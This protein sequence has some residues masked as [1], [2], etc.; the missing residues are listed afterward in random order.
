MT[1]VVGGYDVNEAFLEASVPLVELIASL[2]IALLIYVGTGQLGGVLQGPLGPR[3]PAAG[4]DPGPGDPQVEGG[5]S[6]RSP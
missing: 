2:M 1:P 4:G 6:V 5:S 3:S